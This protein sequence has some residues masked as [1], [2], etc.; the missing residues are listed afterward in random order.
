[1]SFSAKGKK[2]QGKTRARP[3]K[4]E[5]FQQMGNLQM[6]L[7]WLKKKCTAAL[8]PRELR[9]LVDH[10]KTRNATIS[11]QCEL[12]GLPRSTLYYSPSLC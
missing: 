10:D 4:A 1:V 7:E 11:R 12:L 2:T 9:K 6:E 3:R 8:M 5:L